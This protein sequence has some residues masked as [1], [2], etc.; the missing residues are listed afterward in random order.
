MQFAQ[1][2]KSDCSPQP[3]YISWIVPPTCVSGLYGPAT[4][5][6]D[7]PKG[8]G[9]IEMYDVWAKNKKDDEQWMY[10]FFM[11]RSSLRACSNELDADKWT[12]SIGL[13]GTYTVNADVSSCIFNLCFS[14]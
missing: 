11:G 5:R 12:K 6:L 7:Y 13:P 14:F 4:E 1:Q 8:F 3:W 10:A 2:M 9:A